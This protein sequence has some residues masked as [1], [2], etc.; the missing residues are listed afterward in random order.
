MI[1]LCNGVL[2]TYIGLTHFLKWGM[3]KPKL[4][5]QLKLTLAAS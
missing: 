3:K 2:P 5:F 4:A 1:G